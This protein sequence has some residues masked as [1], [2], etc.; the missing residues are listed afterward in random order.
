MTLDASPDPN[1]A[2]TI[3]LRCHG[4]TLTERQAIHQEVQQHPNLGWEHTPTVLRTRAAFK[5]RFQEFKDQ[6]DFLYQRILEGEKVPV[7][8]RELFEAEIQPYEDEDTLAVYRTRLAD[9]Q[10]STAR[11][12]MLEFAALYGFQEELLGDTMVGTTDKREEIVNAV[13]WLSFGR[14]VLQVLVALLLYLA[15]SVVY[16]TFMPWW[17]ALILAVMV[18][19]FGPSS[20]TWFVTVKGTRVDLFVHW[21]TTMALLGAALLVPAVLYRGLLVT[22]VIGGYGW[23]PIPYTLDADTPYLLTTP[24][25]NL[26]IAQSVDGSNVQ[27]ILPDLQVQQN[28]GFL[29]GWLQNLLITSSF[30]DVKILQVPT[31]PGGDTWFNVLLL[32]L[33]FVSGLYLWGL[34]L[35]LMGL[36]LMSRIPGSILKEMSFLANWGGV[37]LFLALLDAFWPAVF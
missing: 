8:W 28:A 2:L 36:G 15:A 19:G 13:L 5:Y 29:Q 10:V 27:T 3:I 11:E 35:L 17:V 4:H 12:V 25:F 32:A 33:P 18:L 26:L 14:F 24:A 21:G 9:Q 20:N 7:H 16:H 30:Q 31:L 34:A 37:F 6:L 22:G 23:Q 1:P